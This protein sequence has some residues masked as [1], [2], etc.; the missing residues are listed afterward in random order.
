MHAKSEGVEI[1]IEPLNRYEDHMVNR[2]EQGAALCELVDLSS[3]GVVADIFHMGIEETNTPAA[4]V[5]IRRWLRHLH[6]ADSTR[7]EPGSGQTD[8]TA[9]KS[10]L[11]GI[12]YSGFVALEC[13]L[14][15]DPL[16]A[17]RRAATT[18]S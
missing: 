15:G 16:E 1:W 18:L 4:L 9:I 12:G 7:A 11:V 8:F 5:T 17:L 3:V 10:A 13:R 14:I 2:L 6:G